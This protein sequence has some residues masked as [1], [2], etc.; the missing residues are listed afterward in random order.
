MSRLLDYTIYLKAQYV[1]F[2]RD[3]LAYNGV[4]EYMRIIS[5]KK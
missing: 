5:S 1:K 3:L 4:K 2:Q